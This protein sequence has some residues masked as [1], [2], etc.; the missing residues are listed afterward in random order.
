VIRYLS[1]F[2]VP[3]LVSALQPAL[4]HRSSGSRL[5]LPADHRNHGPR[6]TAWLCMV[7]QRSKIWDP[8]VVPVLR[9]MYVNL[10]YGVAFPWDPWDPD[11]MLWYVQYICICR[12][13]EF[14]HIV[15]RSYIEGRMAT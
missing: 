11:D 6:D 14:I 9:C 7:I 4:L 8:T 2:P 3:F 5:Q 15:H 12:V 10:E 1:T 13:F